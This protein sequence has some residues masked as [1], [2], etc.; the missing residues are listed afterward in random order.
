MQYSLNILYS[1]VISAV[2][3]FV[4]SSIYA[5]TLEGYRMLE[6]DRETSVYGNILLLVEGCIEKA[7]EDALRRV[8]CL[9]F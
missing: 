4:P 7:K 9:L 8:M 5:N 6:T 1:I 3:Y 2:I